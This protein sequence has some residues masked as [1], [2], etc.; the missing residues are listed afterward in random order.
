M[1]VSWFVSNISSKLRELNKAFEVIRV[2]APMLTPREYINP[3]YTEKD[4]FV[5]EDLALR[6]ETTMGSYEYAKHLL[7]SHTGVRMP[8]CVWQLGK[9]YRREQDQ[10]L[11]R[12]RL[13]E[14]YQLE[15]QCIYSHTTKND[16]TEPLIQTVQK[17]ISDFVVNRRFNDGCVV[18]E[19]D[20]LPAYAEWT[21]DVVHPENEMEL[22][23]MSLRKDFPDAKVFEIAI[24]IDRCVA[25]Y[26]DNEI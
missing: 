1:M 6:P 20:R 2:E 17:L 14:F 21:Q 24:G 10:P 12:M 3:N 5:F 11:T 4:I 18:V 19:S 22:C 23:S 9:S 26:F 13:K 7:T 8:L 16:Y 25:C 15:F